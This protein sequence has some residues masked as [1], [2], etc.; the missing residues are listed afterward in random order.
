MR[1][2]PTRPPL[3]ASDI[4]RNN[5]RDPAALETIGLFSSL[6]RLAGIW[7]GLD[8]VRHA[9]DPLLTPEARALRYKQSFEKATAVA[10]EEVRA[11]ANKLL[12]TKSKLLHDA[13]GRAGLLADYG[14]AAELRAVLRA[15]PQAERDAAITHAAAIGDAA[16]MTA[17]QTHELLIGATTVPVKVITDTFIAERAPE[18][19]AQV[20]D[21]DAAI[22]HLELAYG[23]FSRSVEGMR[24]LQLERAGDDEAKAA[25]E[26]DAKLGLALQG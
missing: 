25:R 2:T 3:L 19:L 7:E 8:A 20:A 10:T 13:R 22:E 23:Q 14:N 18:Q 16:V 24:D 12:D 26:A 21:L 11:T 17:I 4:A 15:M 9:A 5:L 1:R 6:N